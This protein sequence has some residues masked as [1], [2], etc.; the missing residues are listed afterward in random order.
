ME[1][2]KKPLIVKAPVD[3]ISIK[4]DKEYKCYSQQQQIK[5]YYFSF[6]IEDDDGTRRFCLLRYCSNILDQDW[7]AV[8]SEEP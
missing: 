4:K 7:I 2:V 1:N 3:A 6:Y 5:P 8:K